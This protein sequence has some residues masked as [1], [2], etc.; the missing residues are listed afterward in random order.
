MKYASFTQTYGDKRR[1]E[2][3]LLKYDNIGNLFRKKCDLIIFSFHNCSKSIITEFIDISKTLYPEEKLRVLIYNN[4]SYLDSIKNTI[5]YLIKNN[6]DYILQIQDDQFGLNNT[7]NNSN[8]INNVNTIFTFIET[9]KPQY[10]NMLSNHGD[11]NVNKMKVYEEFYLNNIEFYK[12]N[13]KEFRYCY[14]FNDGTFLAS[15]ELLKILYFLPN[16]PEN[17]W[18]LENSLCKYFL[19]NN[20]DRW[21][22]NKVIF[23]HLCIHGKNVMLINER[24]EELQKYF[25]D[26]EMWDTEIE[27]YILKLM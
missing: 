21:G 19:A 5:L 9:K 12:Y 10:F 22:M 20:F 3:N 6:I 27:D 23:G 8:I 18:D 17:I 15:I 26:L 2:I 1:S 25:K 13:S 14:S 24:K 11:K 7:E 16:L 4:C